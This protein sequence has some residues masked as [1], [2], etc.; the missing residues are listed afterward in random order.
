MYSEDCEIKMAVDLKNIINIII[1][2]KNF[3]AILNK[4]KE[5][6]NYILN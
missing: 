5:Y 6:F 3:K 4:L 2:Y 1:K